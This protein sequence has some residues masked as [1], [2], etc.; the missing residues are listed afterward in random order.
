MRIL[1]LFTLTL[2]TACGS[3]VKKF[4]SAEPQETDLDVL[5]ARLLESADRLVHSQRKAQPK[6]WDVSMKESMTKENALTP[7]AFVLNSGSPPN[8]DDGEWL[9][10]GLWNCQKLKMGSPLCQ[11]DPWEHMTAQ[12]TTE[13]SNSEVTGQVG[14][15]GTK[16]HTLTAYCKK[17]GGVE[18]EIQTP[19]LDPSYSGNELEIGFDDEPFVTYQLGLVKTYEFGSVKNFTGIVAD[20]E[21]L[22]EKLMGDFTSVKMR[23]VPANS[24]SANSIQFVVKNFPRAWEVACGWHVRY[25]AIAGIRTQ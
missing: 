9:N 20:T 11:D 14:V 24:A 7:P 16:D 3:N 18:I 25:D 21:L 2:L 13:D 22:L 5:A 17:S 1:I 6:S 4:Y 23:T 8:P 10:G 12:Y 19:Y 15:H